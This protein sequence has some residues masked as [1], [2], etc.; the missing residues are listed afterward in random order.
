M[1]RM[2]AR[3]PVADFA[4]WWSGYQDFAQL[5]VENG[6]KADA[7]YQAVDDPN[8]VTVSHDFETAEAAA[9]FVSL[10]ELKSAME[11]IGVTGPP[12]IWITQETR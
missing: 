10:P 7:V 2:F 5:R 12:T 6:V 9:A 3:H 11:E 4:R 8:D 1:V